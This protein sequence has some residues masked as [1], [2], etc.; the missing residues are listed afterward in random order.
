M[1]E[2]NTPIAEAIAACDEI[3]AR[4]EALQDM[5]TPK[6]VLT[7]ESVIRPDHNWELHRPA[8]LDCP[9]G[10]VI[11]ASDG[12]R[13]YRLAPHQAADWKSNT[14]GTYTHGALWNSLIQDAADGI[15]F[16]YTGIF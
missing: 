2:A 8:D 13:Y 6:P 3:K 7:I 14:G 9:E 11:E 4:L 10:T 12:W 1:T 15:A 16:E 5:F